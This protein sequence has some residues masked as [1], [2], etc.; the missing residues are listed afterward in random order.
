MVLPPFPGNDLIGDLCRLGLPR[1][2]LAGPL[3]EPTR[4]GVGQTLA[5]DF[6]REKA[7]VYGITLDQVRN[8]LFNAYGARQIGTIYTPSNDYQIIRADSVLELQARYVIETNDKALIFVENN[9]MRE[10]PPE[11][12][13]KQAAGELVDPALIYFR[14]V[15]RFE[16]AAPQYQWLMR[17]IFLCAAARFP[18][19]VQIRFF[20][21]T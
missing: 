8:Q 4:I 16:T 1:F 17:R 21:V 18:D 15:P 20:E 11:L 2:H 19:R 7:A 9:G 12:L 3:D 13:A 10:G 14:T 5:V 6:D